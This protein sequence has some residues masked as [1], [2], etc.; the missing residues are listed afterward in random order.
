VETGV[1]PPLSYKVGG[2]SGT[3]VYIARP[4]PDVPGGLE[5]VAENVTSPLI[6]EYELP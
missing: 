4:N 1:T 5:I 3:E 2:P 6:D